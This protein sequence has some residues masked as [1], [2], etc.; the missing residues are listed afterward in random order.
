MFPTNRPFFL[1][2]LLFG[3][4]LSIGVCRADTLQ[5][6][7]E[8]SRGFNLSTYA[9]TTDS[10]K[11]DLPDVPDI[12]FEIS[13]PKNWIERSALGQSYGEIVRYDGPPLGDTRPYFS[14]KRLQMKRENSARLEL[15]AYMLK[16]GYVLRSL[17]E[18]DDRNVEALYVVTDKT[19]SFAVRT[20]GRIIGPALVLAEYGLP[21]QAWDY[22]RDEQTFAIRSFKFLKDS[23]E[24]IEQRLER[25]YFKALHFSYPASWGFVSETAP[26]D[27]IVHVTIANMGDG[28]LEVGRM[29]LT[30]VSPRSLKDEGN[31]TDFPVDVTAMLKD[32]RKSY[33]DREYVFGRTLETRK[34]DLHLQTGLAMLETYELRRRLS[35]YEAADHA[36]V[37]HELWLAVF[38]TIQEPVKTYVVELF[39]PSRGQD[40]YLWSINSRAFEIVLKSIQ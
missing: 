24:H 16:Q 37:T 30:L 10:I 20:I 38:R 36:P 35:Q 3:F 21:L 12:A 34:P 31:E 28:G 23:A 11:K 13:L 22:L 27:N 40:I 39:T 5:P 2:A 18:I 6:L 9:G 14:L 26:Q 7:P 19:D 17:K 8:L 15:I 1:P 32:I 33:E 29:R 25:S 4:F